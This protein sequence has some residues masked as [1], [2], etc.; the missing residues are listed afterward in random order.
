V[1]LGGSLPPGK[2]FSPLE[3][4]VGRSLKLLDIVFKK[5]KKWAP[6]SKLFF[7]LVYQAGYGPV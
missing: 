7:P 6:L 1:G 4:F 3:N 5:R 2:H